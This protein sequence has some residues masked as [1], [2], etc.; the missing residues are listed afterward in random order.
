MTL[1]LVPEVVWGLFGLR[2]FFFFYRG[3]GS[4]DVNVKS[5]RMLEF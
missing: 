4:K 3:S 1:F 2:I 5:V